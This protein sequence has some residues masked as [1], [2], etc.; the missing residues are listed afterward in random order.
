MQTVRRSTP[1]SV[2]TDQF[3]NAVEVLS[4]VNQSDISEQNKEEEVMEIEVRLNF[5]T[6]IRKYLR[7]AFNVN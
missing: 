4:A 1:E 3:A 2:V 6:W 7:S 5:I